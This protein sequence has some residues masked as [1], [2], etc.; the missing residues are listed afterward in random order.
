MIADA[1]AEGEQSLADGMRKLPDM[2]LRSC[3]YHLPTPAEFYDEGLS[4]ILWL[5]PDAR[6]QKRKRSSAAQ[7]HAAPRCPAPRPARR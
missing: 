4:L 3:C 6:K 7:R 5:E 2:S 1:D